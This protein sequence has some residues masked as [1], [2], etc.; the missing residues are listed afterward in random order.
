M[1]TIILCLIA[2][3]SHAATTVYQASLD[4][5]TVVHGAAAADSDVHHTAPKSL[6]IEPGGQYPDAL[7]RSAPVSLTIG[8]RYELSGWVRTE[9]LTVRDTDRSPIATGAALSMASMPFDVHSASLG[10]TQPLDPPLPQVHRHPLA[11]RRSS[12]PSPTAARSR[13]RRG[14]KASRLDEASAARRLARP[15]SRP[16]LRPRLPLSRRRLDLPAHRRQALRA[17]LPARLP[18]GARDP[19][20]PRALRRRPRRQRRPDGANIR[21]M[22]NALFLRGFDR[23]ILEE[24]RGIADGAT[25]AGAKWQGRR[26][27]LV[28]IVVANITV[29]LGELRSPP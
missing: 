8:K 1:R 12:S 14:S 27:D 28:D 26:I 23:E 20:I 5:L 21:T 2:V 9:N 6:R 29:E 15:R 19:R 4:Q 18:D 22:A 10:G 7:V 17:R 3:A 24:M 25:D 13:A 16:D 11:G